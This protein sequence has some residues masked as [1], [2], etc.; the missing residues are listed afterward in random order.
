[1]QITDLLRGDPLDHTIYGERYLNDSKGRFEDYSEVD[2][3]YDPQGS[4][5]MIQLPY[6]LL[7]PERCIVLQDEPSPYS[8]MESCRFSSNDLSLRKHSKRT[9]WK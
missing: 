1:M 2:P 7:T 4:L 9:S 5:P 6:T 3:K 8:R